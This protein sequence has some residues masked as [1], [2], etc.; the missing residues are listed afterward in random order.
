[1]PITPDRIG[2]SEEGLLKKASYAIYKQDNNLRVAGLKVY[3]EESI[4]GF[5][6]GGWNDEV[7]GFRVFQVF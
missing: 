3:K 7:T 6:L 1:V 2:P 4:T 5:Q